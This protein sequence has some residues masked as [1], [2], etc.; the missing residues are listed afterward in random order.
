M[1]A[2]VNSNFERMR[3]DG[4]RKRLAEIEARADWLARQL[5]DQSAETRRR[6]D[7]LRDENVRLGEIVTGLQ[8][9]LDNG[10]SGTSEHLEDLRARLDGLTEH[11]AKVDLGITE[12]QRLRAAIAPVLAGA[13]RDARAD[14]PAQL[15]SAMAP[16][17]IGTIR[18]EILNSEDELIEAIHPRL[19]LL[20]SAAITNA[21]DELNRKVDEALPVD[22]WMASVKSR[23]TGAPAAGWVLKGGRDFHVKDALLID[24]NS[25][26]LLASERGPQEE[27][28]TLD[29]DLVA[30]MIA[31]LQ[32]FASD[33]YGATGAGEL[34]RF[35][36]TED[37]V[38]LRGTPT[39]ILALRCSGVAPPEIESKVDALLVAALERLREAGDVSTE[40]FAL[41]GL[42][43]A[44]D[45]QAVAGPSASRIAAGM[46]GAVAA[47]VALVWGHGAVIDIHES[48][49]VQ[50]ATDAARADASLS[51]YPID[52]ALDPQGG[53]AITISGLLRDQTALDALV[54]RVRWTATPVDIVYDI[55]L[56]EGPR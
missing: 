52:V 30:G 45:V 6:N 43:T 23:L 28:E 56:I 3:A 24:R 21:I 8:A 12:P 32:G 10:V 20:I 53:D 9:A 40:I 22:R 14:D 35:S 33:A 2:P 25:G 27:S 48:R 36:F 1:K 34:R 38:Y 37:T 18:S 13:L 31:A 16:S 19:G 5:A 11:I 26:V 7:A 46:I 51:P 17:M 50:A 4:E 42:E 54:E 29:E 47:S 44:P 39:K 15:S 49:W 41:E 55:A